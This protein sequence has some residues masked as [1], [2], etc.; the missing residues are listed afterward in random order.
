VDVGS[1]E[2][3]GIRRSFTS[4]GNNLLGVLDA[5]TA[6]FTNGVN[7]DYVKPMGTT[8]QYVVT[9][10]A[11][12]W[13]S[14]NDTGV[15]LVLSLREAIN[16][17][18]NTAG[19][20]EIW[21]PAWRMRMMRAGT[22]YTDQGDFDISS[23]MTIRGIGPGMSVIDAGI[24]ATDDRIFDVASTGVLNLSRVT[25]ALGQ[26]PNTSGQRDGGAVRVQNGGQLNLDYSA[27]VGNATSRKG[28]GGAIYFAAS[29][30]GSITNSVITV[31]EADFDTGGV[32]LAD[33]DTPESAGAVYVANSIIVN[34]SDGNATSYPDV[35]AGDN[36]EFTSGGHNRLGNAATGFGVNGDYF[37]PAGTFVH[38]VVTGVADTYGSSNLVNMSLR[39]AIASAN[40]SAGGDEIWLPAWTF[41]LTRDRATFGQGSTD[42][43][44]SFGDL[45]IVDS[46][47][48]RGIGGPSVPATSVNWLTSVVADKVFELVGDYNLDGVVNPADDSV[49]PSGSLAA[50]GDDNGVENGADLTVRQN[51]NGHT[52]TH[53]G[54]QY[55]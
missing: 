54:I 20:E 12:T 32:Y 43:E 38:Y 26:S 29:G 17:A 9:G 4:G 28:Y 34:N 30:H 2:N 53:D 6:G 1:Q 52:W 44:A 25:L 22:G 41:V 51:N 11:D 8:V 27:V 15:P 3:A 55:V 21:L 48:I 23:V 19:A 46:L 50:D 45:D 24:L 5:G 18:N 35:Y 16:K 49:L 39:D 42:M 31:N 47:T 7:G 33:A 14:S 13:D 10:V 37:K 36:R 40:N